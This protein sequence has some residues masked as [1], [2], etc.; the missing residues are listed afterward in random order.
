MPVKTK[1]SSRRRS[2]PQKRGASRP[3]AAEPRVTNVAIIGAGAGGSAL[4]TVLAPD[5]LVRIVGVAEINPRAPGLRLAKRYGIPVTR[6]FRDLLGS[7]EVDLI[8]DVTGSPEVE[9]ALHELDRVGVAVIRGTSAKFMWQLIEERVLANA[10]IKRHLKKF[11]ELSKLYEKEAGSAITGERSRIACEIHDGLVQTLA[12]INLKLDLCR[13]LIFSDPTHS[14]ELLSDA[15]AQLKTAI[16]ESRQ[17]IFNLRPLYFESMELVPA[18]KNYLKSYETQSHIRT[19][20]MWSGGESAMAPTTKIVLFRIVQEALSNVQKHAKADRT[21]ISLAVAQGRI[22]GTI[23]DN[24]IG[25]DVEAMSQDP[26]KWQSFGLKG[27]HER[28]RLIGGTARVESRKG[29]GTRVLVDV[30]ISPEEERQRGADQGP[31]RR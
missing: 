1:L 14:F 3:D 20:L 28:A 6:N 4:L 8:I 21:T 29:H 31:D 5:P 12:G 18:L 16:D 23:E 22:K 7:E 25:F 13:E 27:I 17:V 11:Q 15:K 2:T 30:P 19:E 24:G 9:R 10:E 26:T